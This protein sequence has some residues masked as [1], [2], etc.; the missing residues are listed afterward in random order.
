MTAPAPPAPLPPPAIRIAAI[1]FTC[2]PVPSL[3][4]VE[5]FGVVKTD[6]PHNKLEGWTLSLRGAAMFLVSPAGWAQHKA[7]NEWPKNGPRTIC[8]I[9]RAACSIAWEASEPALI[10]KLTRHDQLLERAAPTQEA[11]AIA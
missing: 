7:A 8:E 9:P 11:E 4:N 5:A 2:P 1:R 6:V 3:G 10:D